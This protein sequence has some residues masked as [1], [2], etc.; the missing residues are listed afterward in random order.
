M[1]AWEGKKLPLPA[2]LKVIGIFFVCEFIFW[3]LGK[4]FLFFLPPIY[5]YIALPIGATWLIAK[6]KLD[7]KAPHRWL[8]GMIFYWM[9]PKRTHRYRK[10]Q[11]MK[12]YKYGSKVAYRI[13]E[14]A[15]T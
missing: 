10:F 5:T 4:T 7:G 13:E 11:H 2:N 3:M 12:H 15:R 8:L 14:R 9:R 6:Q 1:Y